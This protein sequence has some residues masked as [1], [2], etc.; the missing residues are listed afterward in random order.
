MDAHIA[1]QDDEAILLESQW[2]WFTSEGADQ[3]D[4]DSAVPQ[5]RPPALEGV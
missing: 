1:T 5:P 2:D 3:A 4:R